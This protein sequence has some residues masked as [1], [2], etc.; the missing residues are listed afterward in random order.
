[1]RHSYKI[2]HVAV[3]SGP[4]PMMPKL[5][6]YDQT[7]ARPGGTSFTRAYIEKKTLISLL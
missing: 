6:P 3:S 7:K 2:L 5:Y 1:M 4:L